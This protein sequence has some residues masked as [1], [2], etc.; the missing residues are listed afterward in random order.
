METSLI[1][2]RIA[3]MLGITAKDRQAAAESLYLA[4]EHN[5]VVYW[6]QLFIAAGIAHLGLVLNSN[7]VIIGAMLVSP[8]MTPIVQVG[9]G[10]ALGNLYLTLKAVLRI[11]LSIGTVVALSAV[12]IKAMPYENLTAE[13]L[14]RTQPTALDLFVALFCGFAASFTTARMSSA[15]VTAAAGTAI[16]IA[17]VPPLCV[18]GIGVGMASPPVVMGATL[19]FVANLAAIV[20]ISDLFFLATGFAR[21]DVMGLE[22]K[23]IHSHDRETPLYRFSKSIHPGFG[24]GRWRLFRILLPL[25]FV[26]VVFIPLQK[27]LSRVTWEM[28]VKKN[29]ARALDRFE[30]GH[31]VLAK[32]QAVSFGTVAVRLSVVGEPGD[33]KK[34]EDDLRLEV[35]ALSG[36]KPDVRVEVIPSQEFMD[37]RLS[38]STARLDEKL[39]YLKLQ[40]AEQAQPILP[41]PPAVI[42]KELTVPELF[43]R[44]NK[45]VEKQTAFL[46]A[47]DPEGRWL[48]WSFGMGSRGPVLTIRRIADE[49][50]S[51]SARSLMASVFQKELSLPVTVEED[52]VPRT[53]FARRKSADPRGFSP[54]L[55]TQ[56]LKKALEEPGLSI[57][58]EL[59]ENDPKWKRLNKAVTRVV[60]SV[61]PEDRRELALCEGECR[62][63]LSPSAQPAAEIAGEK[64]Q[65]APAPQAALPVAAGGGEKP[66]ESPAG[67]APATEP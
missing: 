11:L 1:S 66:N 49:P 25:V 42:E 15:S 17:L 4:T 51:E 67:N 55:L 39:A 56:R 3:K 61:V 2:S 54:V 65:E 10:F 41:P 38:E 12:L 16:A 48:S 59:P 62:I 43:E 47:N 58:L 46:A 19:L 64:K 40:Q 18:V 30:V 27:A 8:L 14:A 29:L 36:T 23:V 22:G 45:A 26:A 13:I 24:M 33:R 32:R 31:Q 60:S 6:I 34:L 7:A 9:M 28:N 20:L 57:R 37:R 63:V 44:L 5:P 53:L 35:A 21:V 50:L 52:P